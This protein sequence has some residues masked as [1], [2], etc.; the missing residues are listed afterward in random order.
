M[1]VLASVQ[2]DYILSMKE[3]KDRL[4]DKNHEEGD[5]EDW[6]GLWQVAEVCGHVHAQAK[7][8]DVD[9]EREHLYSHVYPYQACEVRD[10]DENLGGSRSVKQSDSTSKDLSRGF[11]KISPKNMQ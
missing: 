3:A 4:A 5:S 8:D 11:S 2:A 6:M 9:E 7:G 1:H 10:P